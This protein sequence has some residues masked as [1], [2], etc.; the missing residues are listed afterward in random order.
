MSPKL[1]YNAVKPGLIC[2]IHSIGGGV[3]HAPSHF[4]FDL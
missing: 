1:Q 4:F 2:I 3:T